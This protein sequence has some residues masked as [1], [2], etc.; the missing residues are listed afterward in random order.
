MTN[1][2]QGLREVVRNLE[3]AGVEASDLKGVFEPIGQ[4]IVA[5]ARTLAPK[6]TGALGLALKSTKT[7][8][9]AA[10]RAGSARV[11]YA[12]AINYGWPSRNI[13]ASLFLQRA[14]DSNE[15]KAIQ[16]MDEGL[17]ELF[18]RLLT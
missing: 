1:Y 18:N 3:K 11:Q 13:K 10:V 17:T 4:M 12:G 16:M 8:N 6:R 15:S 7:K 2:V 9:K 14:I 5:D